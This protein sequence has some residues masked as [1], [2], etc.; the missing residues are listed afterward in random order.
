LSAEALAKEDPRLIP[1][2]LSS[3]FLVLLIFLFLG[4]KIRADNFENEN[5]YE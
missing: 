3:I 2:R 4:L 5:D 1:S